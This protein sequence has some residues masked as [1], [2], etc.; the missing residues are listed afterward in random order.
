MPADILGWLPLGGEEEERLDVWLVQMRTQVS[1]VDYLALPAHRVETDPETGEILQWRF[2]CA[3]FVIVAYREA[4]GVSLVDQDALPPS[5]EGVVAAIWGPLAR[6]KDILRDI[7]LGSPPPW[8]VLLPG[9]VLRA[10]S[11]VGA[12]NDRTCLPHRPTAD[13]A[14]FPG[15]GQDAGVKE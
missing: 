4:T 2:S 6:R 8:P 10:L 9:H 12:D 3:G 11:L 5:D 1:N 15:E 7:G 13:D 14:W